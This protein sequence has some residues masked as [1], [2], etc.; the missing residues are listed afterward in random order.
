MATE[1]GEGTAETDD[2]AEYM[3]LDDEATA[4]SDVEA[5]DELDEESGYSTYA[6]S[7][8]VT[9]GSTLSG[10]GVALLSALYLEDPTGTLPLLLVVAAVFLQRFVYGLMGMDVDDF[11]VKGNLYIGVMTFA[12]WFITLGI[13]LTTGATDAL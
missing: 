7:V 4:E 6:R 9:I 12:L 8:I 2:D 3:D 11:G 5:E 13:V 1:T 10:M